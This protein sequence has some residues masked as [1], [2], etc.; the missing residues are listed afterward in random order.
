LDLL[1]VLV[2]RGSITPED[3]SEYKTQLRRAGYFFVPVNGD[4]LAH[5]LDASTVKDD[6]VIE[7]AELK[8]IRENVLR[9]RMSTWL[10]LPKEAPWLDTSLRVF[11][12]VLKS[13]W[14]ADSDLSS[15]RARSDWIMNQIDVRGWAHSLGYENGD[16]LVKFGR[17]A[18]ILMVLSPPADAPQEVKDEYWIWV[19]DRVLAPIKEQYPD[20]YSWIVEWQRRQIAEMANMDLTK[21]VRNDE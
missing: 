20:L 3:Q 18:Y 4:E 15:A 13:L 5:H 1:D 9:V 8:A 14:R 17:G 10:Q 21:G 12:R 6:K 2:S 11:I 16:N 7:T 19:E